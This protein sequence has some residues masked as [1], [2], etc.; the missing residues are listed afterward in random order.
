MAPVRFRTV[1]TRLQR[2]IVDHE[3]RTGHLLTGE[4]RSELFEQQPIADALMGE[5]AVAVAEVRHGA[6]GAVGSTAFADLNVACNLHLWQ[7][8]TAG[9]W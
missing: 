9:G 8:W 4:T 5:V 7:W 3:P 1:S 2:R 6:C